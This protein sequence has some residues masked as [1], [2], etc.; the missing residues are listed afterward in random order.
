MCSKAPCSRGK[1]P[2][3]PPPS[4]QYEEILGWPPVRHCLGLHD[5]V[6]TLDLAAIDQRTQ[7]GAVSTSAAQRAGDGNPFSSDP[8]NVFGAWVDNAVKPPSSNARGAADGSLAVGNGTTTTTPPVVPAQRH[9]GRGSKAGGPRRAESGDR[10]R[11]RQ[12]PSDRSTARYRWHE[13]AMRSS[14][15][16]G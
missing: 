15:C 10:S 1:A 11:G 12:A 2:P 13:L 4:L 16:K 14:S 3:P 8:I 5:D 7:C 6:L 9:S